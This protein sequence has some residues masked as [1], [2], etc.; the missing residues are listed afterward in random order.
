[1]SGFI[2]TCSE[3]KQSFLRTLTYCHGK[4]LCP[5]CFKKEMSKNKK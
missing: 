2:N 4:Y 3:C 5:S 1:M